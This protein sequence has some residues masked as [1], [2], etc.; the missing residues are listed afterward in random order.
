MSNK[1]FLIVNL[2]IYE[3]DGEE[4]YSSILIAKNELELP[5]LLN[6]AI[7]NIE[8]QNNLELSAKLLGRNLEIDAVESHVKNAFFEEK[9]VFTYKNIVENEQTHPEHVKSFLDWI[10]G[11]AESEEYIQRI[12]SSLN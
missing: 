3:T 11:P 9:A 6:H 4:E 10:N 1:G 5:L 7:N 8:K 12:I 2:F